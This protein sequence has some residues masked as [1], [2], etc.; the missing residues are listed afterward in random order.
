MSVLRLLGAKIGSNVKISPNVVILYPERLQIGNNSNIHE[1]SVLEC[2]GGLSIGIGCSIA[3]KFSV[4][5]TTHNISEEGVNF[6]DQGL[7]SRKVVIG[8]YC[9]IGAGVVITYGVTIASGVVIG[10]NAVVTKSVEESSLA[11]GVPAKVR[12][13]LAIDVPQSN[14]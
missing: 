11:L 1:F 6:R 12:K 2:K 10:A 14:T 8:D 3:H 5:T 7:T 9:W 13:R 4:L